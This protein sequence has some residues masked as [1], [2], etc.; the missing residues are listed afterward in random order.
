MD[1]R[2]KTWD[3]ACFF[4]TLVLCERLLLVASSFAPI[5]NIKIWT[6]LSSILW[7]QL[8]R[9]FKLKTYKWLRLLNVLSYLLVTTLVIIGQFSGR[10]SALHVRLVKL[11]SY[12]V[13]KLSSHLSP[14]VL[15]FSWFWNQLVSFSM[16]IWS[17][18][19]RIDAISETCQTVVER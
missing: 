7:Q 18:S 16:F 19:T 8:Q 2:A 14:I 11:Q 9:I 13:A 15:V 4:C 6:S 17:R 1:L 12:F 10:Y 3:V 5:Q